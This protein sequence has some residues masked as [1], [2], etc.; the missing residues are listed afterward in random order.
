MTDKRV[1][2]IAVFNDDIKGY[3]KFSEDLINNRVKI[4]LKSY[5]INPELFARFSHT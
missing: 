5:W 4:D 2:A 3:V 1:Y